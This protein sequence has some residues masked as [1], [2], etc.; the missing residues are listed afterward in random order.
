MANISQID[1]FGG[2][3]QLSAAL[4]ISWTT[5]IPRRK[6]PASQLGAHTGLPNGESFRVLYQSSSELRTM[7][8]IYKDYVKGSIAQ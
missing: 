1:G 5:N 7:Q 2:K 6:C 3:R 4:S 8:G